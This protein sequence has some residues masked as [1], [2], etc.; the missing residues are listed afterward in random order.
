MSVCELSLTDGFPT[1]L[2]ENAYINRIPLSVTFELTP[3]CNFSCV[4]C[5]VHL[6]PEQ[7]KKQGKMLSAE[8]WIELAKQAKEMG[9]LYITLTG[10]EPFTRPDF[11]EI[12]SQLN[13]MGFLISVLSNG[14]LIDESVIEKFREYGMPYM[15]KLSSY[16]ASDET[17][18]RTCG[19]HEGCTRL[20]RA[21]KLI[22]EAGIPLAVT[23]TVVRENADDLRKMYES[24]RKWGVPFTHTV[25]IVKSARGA[26]NSAETSRF[27][28]DEF[29]DGMTL[30]NIKKNMFP[31]LETP[32]AWCSSYR[33]SAWITWNGN[34]QLCSF[35][36]APY[37]TLENGFKSAWQE[38]GIKLEALK[39]PSECTDCKYSAFCQRCPG[40]L[41]GESG[42]AEKAD[43]ALCN[44][45]KRLYEAYTKLTKEELT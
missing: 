25:S 9:T 10:G 24:A 26:V 29:I 40:L 39:S 23:G 14:Y 21:V 17:Y 22:K 8:D 18:F 3:L 2:K 35:M 7:M 42:N 4:M 27:S 6:T 31:P 12:Y 34:M 1:G 44:T 13:E 32:F 19:V 5:Y 41:C 16:G 20:E 33:T 43:K 11:W 15:I 45:A 36:N 38:L 30:E 37:A 28:F